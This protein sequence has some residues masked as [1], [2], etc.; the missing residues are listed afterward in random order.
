MTI[1]H[2]HQSDSPINGYI[3][4]LFS[5]MTF[6]MEKPHVTWRIRRK[7]HLPIYWIYKHQTI[8]SSW[9]PQE[10]AA[11]VLAAIQGGVWANLLLKTVSTVPFIFLVKIR[12]NPYQWWTVQP[13]G[14]DSPYIHHHFSDITTWGHNLI[15]KEYP[16][17][18]H[19]I[20]TI[21]PVKKSF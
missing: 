19:H 2:H 10:S 3:Y 4:T 11:P 17:F 5:G 21:S 15:H 16:K 18:I 7:Q 9:S 13:F 20:R 6:P 12:Q 1:H 8:I 14:G